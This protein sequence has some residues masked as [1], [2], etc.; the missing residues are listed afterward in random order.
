MVEILKTEIEVSYIL[1]FWSVAEKIG[2]N[3]NNDKLYSVAKFL[4]GKFQYAFSNRSAIYV[5]Y[6]SKVAE[7]P[8]ELHVFTI[9]VDLTIKASKVKVI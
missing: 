2:Q 4:C 3:A 5:F 6:F 7:S 9:R 8:K 1:L